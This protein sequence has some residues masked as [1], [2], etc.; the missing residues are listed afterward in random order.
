MSRVHSPTADVEGRRLDPVHLLLEREHRSRNIDDRIERSDLVKMHAL[1]R[2][3]MNR[4]FGFAQDRKQ[5][6][7]AILAAPFSAEPSIR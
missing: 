3:S 7:G 6:L 5:V 4:G 2:H 1:Q